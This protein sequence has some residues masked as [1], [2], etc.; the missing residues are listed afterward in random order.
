MNRSIHISC[1]RGGKVG[2]SS[3]D[4]LAPV[5]SGDILNLENGCGDL[6]VVDTCSSNE[7]VVVCFALGWTGV[8]YVNSAGERA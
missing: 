2:G 8:T 3:F 5:D 1:G 7:R 6:C 4:I